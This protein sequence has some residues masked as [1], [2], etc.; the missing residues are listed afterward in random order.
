[1]RISRVVLSLLVLVLLVA[2]LGACA[3]VN[4]GYPATAE[5]HAYCKAQNPEHVAVVGSRPV[6]GLSPGKWDPVCG[7][8]S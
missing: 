3:F 7:K 2:G 4:P 6:G 5:D 1:M 8:R